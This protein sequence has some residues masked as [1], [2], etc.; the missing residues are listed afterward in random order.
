MKI[1][2]TVLVCAL[3]VTAS[4]AESLNPDGRVGQVW[5][6]IGASGVFDGEA[7]SAGDTVPLGGSSLDLGIGIVCGSR[8]TIMG[9]VGRSVSTSEETSYYYSGR[10]LIVS[11]GVKLR[12]YLN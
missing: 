6:D 5:F 9:Y 12:V 1:L 2:L 10:S 8:A 4:T 3:C 11:M 7:R